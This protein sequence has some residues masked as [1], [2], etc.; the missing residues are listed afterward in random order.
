M[1]GRAGVR[2]GLLLPLAVARSIRQTSN[3]FVFAF[4][5][6]FTNCFVLCRPQDGVVVGFN[7]SQPVMEATRRS[8]AADKRY[9]FFFYGAFSWLLS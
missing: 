4:S 8:L 5:Y 9:V 2:V 7:L 3:G 1:S 6:F